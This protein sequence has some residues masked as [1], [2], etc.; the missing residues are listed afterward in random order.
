MHLR[1][2]ISCVT[3]C[4]ADDLESAKTV[5]FTARLS[6]LSRKYPPLEQGRTL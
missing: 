5:S 1:M 2:I 6:F 4:D 3:A